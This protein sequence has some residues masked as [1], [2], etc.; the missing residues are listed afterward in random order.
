MYL[1]TYLPMT[2]SQ[3]TVHA[4]QKDKN[5][6][7]F[8]PWDQDQSLEYVSSQF[9][10]FLDSQMKHKDYQKK[11]S[12]IQNDSFNSLPDIESYTQNLTRPVQA[13]PNSSPPLMGPFNPPIPS[14]SPPARQQKESLSLSV[15]PSEKKSSHEDVAGE[16]PEMYN[17][18]PINK[19]GLLNTPHKTPAPASKE[20][21]VI[22]K[23]HVSK[24]AIIST[25]KGSKIMTVNLQ[26]KDSNY[27]RPS[28]SLA[29]PYSRGGD[30]HTIKA[31]SPTASF[32]KT[33]KMVYSTAVE[34][35]IENNGKSSWDEASQ[36]PAGPQ[37]A[38]GS[39]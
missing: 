21:D 38:E 27:K 1:P 29:K 35:F 23:G 22:K 20:N 9:I 33:G 7:L 12:G 30:I 32:S 2:S 34:T 25:S 31:S 5:A 28:T 17:F 10:N 26:K 14:P 6:A 37:R 13:E 11:T 19:K 3:S 39:V 16:E 8:A 36:S 24:E 15:R 4:V 18:K